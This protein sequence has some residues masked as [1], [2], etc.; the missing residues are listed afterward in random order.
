[1]VTRAINSVLLRK[2]K[3][4]KEEEPAKGDGEEDDD[5]ELEMME[6][7]NSQEEAPEEDEGIVEL[8]GKDLVDRANLL[9]GIVVQAA[10]SYTRR[11]LLDC[12]KLTVATMLALRILCLQKSIK[13]EE[14]DVLIRAPPD[15]NPKAMPE[16]ARSWLSETMWAQLFTLEQLPVFK[17]VSGLLT[18]NLEQDS[19]GWRRWYSENRAEASDLPRSFRDIGHFYR[20]LLLRVLRPDRLSAALTQFAH[21]NLGPDFVEQEPFDMQVRRA[22]AV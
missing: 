22:G 15:P 5:G 17:S 9:S 13:K 14:V 18:Q 3:E 4:I 2:P 10:F 19:L 16:S 12:D 1:M 11:G 6:E 20:L 8:Q 21:D 7:S